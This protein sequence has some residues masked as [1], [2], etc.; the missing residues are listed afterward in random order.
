MI[1]AKGVFIAGITTFIIG[2][3]I[4]LTNGKKKDLKDIWGRGQRWFQ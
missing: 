3:Y 2:I 4:I 1:L